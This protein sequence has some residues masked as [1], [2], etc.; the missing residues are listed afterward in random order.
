MDATSTK[1]ELDHLVRAL[2]HDMSANFMLLEN[3]F[4]QLKK[5]LRVLS[6]NG[7][8]RDEDGDLEGTLGRRVAHVDACLRESKRFLDDLVHLAKTG[9]VEME[10]GRVELTAVVDEVLFEQRELLLERGVEVTVRPLLPAVWCNEGRVKQIVTNLVRNAVHHGCDPIEPRMTIGPLPS[11]SILHVEADDTMTGF[12]VHDN[13]PGIPR[14]HR[15]EIFL[16]GRRLAQSAAD[17]SGMGLAIVKK[18]VDHYGGSVCVDPECDEG[19]TF[20]VTLPSAG[21]R[22]TEREVDVEGRRW[23]LQLDARHKECTRHAVPKPQPHLLG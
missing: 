11:D 21:D 23:K 4:W 19:T 18:I 15:R 6:E 1:A 9:K 14:R 22:I 2:S 16:P 3:S 13:G 20:L 17:G 12:A 5:S 10:P 8:P 7:R